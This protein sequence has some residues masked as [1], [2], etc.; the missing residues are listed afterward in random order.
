MLLQEKT[1]VTKTPERKEERLEQPEYEQYIE[2]PYGTEEC[3]ESDDDFV[4]EEETVTGIL[5]R[6]SPSPG[7]QS[8]ETPTKQD[9]EAEVKEID[10]FQLTEEEL[11]HELSQLQF[12]MNGLLRQFS[13]MQA[14]KS[15]MVQQKNTLK[16]KRQF[17]KVLSNLKDQATPTEERETKAIESPET[18]TPERT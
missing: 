16:E 9:R 17:K 1:V 3:E 5:E 7:K 12:E 2:V 11:D 10:I 8:L 6:S 15:K 13:T 18:A 4:A 14:L